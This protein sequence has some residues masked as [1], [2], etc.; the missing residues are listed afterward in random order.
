MALT[1]AKAITAQLKKGE[2]QNLYYIYGQNV[3][4][5]ELLT[6]SI[7]RTAVG[8]NEEFALN[9]LSGKELN[10]S[11]FRDMTEMMPMMS[12]Y[13]CI[14]VNDYNCDEQREETT[15]Q[16]I[17]ALK[18]IP[19]Q[20]VV[21]F[22]VTGFDIKNGRKTITGK[23]KKLVDFVTKNG[24]V[25]EQGIR[26]PAQLAKEIAAKVSARGGMISIANAQELASMCLSDTLMINNEIDKLCAYADGREIT[27][28]ML[29]E[30]VPQQSDI[31]VYNLSAAVCAF[32]RKA[33]FD[34][35]DEL[36]AQRINRG[37][38][39]GT[40]TN[41]FL[42]LYRAACARK[43]GKSIP[44]VMKDFDYKRDFSVKNAFRNSSGMSIK[45]LRAC[46][47]ILRDT[48]AQLNS[49]SADE[50]IMLEEALT[51]MLMTKN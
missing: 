49:T 45:R 6:K 41:S 26:T 12:E 35:L 5:V 34:A 32:N 51:K 24:I 16:L 23:N 46:I 47:A 1:D 17:E 11:D 42:E 14:L 8:D 4:G 19:P 43:S 10:V 40:I 37:I 21:I 38:I 30:L 39:L 33:A 25:C 3:S 18:E 13:N 36:M 20:T 22:N 44:D 15:K 9:K 28:A 27:S 29:H 48:A 7:I 31:T 50:K 2:L